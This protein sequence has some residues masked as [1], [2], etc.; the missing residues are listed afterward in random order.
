LRQEKKSAEATS[1]EE[2]WFLHRGDGI[3]FIGIKIPGQKVIHYDILFPYDSQLELP[4]TKLTTSPEIRNKPVPKIVKRRRRGRPAKVIPA[5]MVN[6]LLDPEKSLREKAWE[7][8]IGKSSVSRKIK[9]VKAQHEVS[10]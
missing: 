3:L 1:K 8:G 7:L 4:L 10:S 6:L 2:Y 5:K 9:E